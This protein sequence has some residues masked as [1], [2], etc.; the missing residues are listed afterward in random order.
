MKSVALGFS[1][2]VDSA[3]CAVLLKNEGFDVKG[4][5]LDNGSG[6]EDA[7]KT[8]D[9]IGIP[10]EVIDVR[11]ELEEK[12]C[13]LFQTAYLE[14]RTPNPCIICNPV[15]KFEKLIEFG[16]DYIATGHYARSENGA[17]Y[18]GHPDNDQSYMLCRLKREQLNRLIF[19]LGS[20]P[21]IRTRQMADEFNLPVASKPDS[22]E[23]CFIPDKDYIGWLGR[24]TALP[25][26]GALMLCGQTVGE[27]DGIYRYTVGQR[28]PGLMNGRKVYIS[29]IDARNNTVEL[30]YWEDLF[31]TTVFAEN[32]SY[33]ADM[34]DEFE[35]TV[36]VRHTKWENPPC[37]VTKNGTDVKIECAEPVRAPAPGQSAVVYQGDRVIG[38]G[39]IT[40]REVF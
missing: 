29:K 36:R 3:V 21:K 24:R 25:G 11:K 17:L 2:G 32:F 8:A 19:P 14:G 37:R 22:M 4:I 13:S 26:P 1:G 40:D 10:L 20:V 35:G 39:F 34:P 38:G 12:V 16:T 6:R 23:I 9:I 15:L 28:Y 18:K 33:L 5:F 27:H 31:K 30:S 7:E